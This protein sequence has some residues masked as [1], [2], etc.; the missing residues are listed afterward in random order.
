MKH[1][2][3]LQ[4]RSEYP[5]VFFTVSLLHRII[6]QVEDRSIT[7]KY[8]ITFSEIMKVLL[9]TLFSLHGNY[10]ALKIWIIFYRDH[11]LQQLK[12]T[13]DDQGH[14][15]MFKLQHKCIYYYQI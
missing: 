1:N 14:S 4:R 9:F 13:D 7:R 2:S 15:G 8:F 3:F 6:Y 11:K 12:G 5:V 10:I